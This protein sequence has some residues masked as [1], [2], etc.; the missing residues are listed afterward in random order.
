[1]GSAIKYSGW[2]KFLFP[3]WS[4]VSSGTIQ[5][6]LRGMSYRSRGHSK[7]LFPQ[8]ISAKPTL[9][10][11]R[12]TLLLSHSMDSGSLLSPAPGGGVLAFQTRF[13]RDIVLTF[14]PPA[15]IIGMCLSTSSPPQEKSEC[16]LTILFF[17]SLYFHQFLYIFEQPFWKTFLITCF[18]CYGAL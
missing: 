17:V 12:F 15:E 13:P 18:P 4:T 5:P 6:G 11:E 9:H 3:R 2:V 16:R 14:I 7:D 10:Q 8:R 1:M